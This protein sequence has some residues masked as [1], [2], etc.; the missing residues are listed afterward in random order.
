M[1]PQ[2]TLDKIRN[3]GI[4]AHID[5]GKT[6]TTERILFYT[7]KIH[8]MG[9]VH[10]GS[11][12]MDWMEQEKERGITITS[13]ATTCFW[14][15]HRINIIDTPGHIDFTVE[16]QRSLRVLDGAVLVLCAVGGVQPQ[17][18]TVW[19]QA[20]KYGV[21]RLSFINKM[22]RVGA[23]FDSVIDQMREKLGAE[24]VALQMPIGAEDDFA[25]VIDLVRLK[26]WTFSDEAANEVEIPE[27]LKSEAESKHFELVE[28]IA[29]LNESL[30]EAYL[31]NDGLNETELIAGIREAVINNEI[32]PV[33]TGSAFK[34]KGVQPLLDA[35]VDYLPA[36]Q[37]L[38]D[39]KFDVLDDDGNVTKQ[40]KTST[41]EDF[42]GLVFKIA[43]DPFVGRLAFVRCYSG[44]MDTGT[45]TY[46]P[47]QD[48][49]ERLGR[50]LL[51]HANQRE[52][53]DKIQAGE[54]AAAVGLKFAKTGDTLTANNKHYFFEKID[55]P[56]TVIDVAIEPKSSVDSK[57][58]Q[59][60][61]AKLEDE[62]PTF[63][64]KTNEDTGQQVISGM[65]ELHLEIIVDRIK[66]EFKVACNVGK[67]QVSYK[68]TIVN[69][70]TNY[71]YT[72]DREA[73][74]KPQY[75][76]VQFDVEPSDRGSGF[77][78]ESRLIKDAFDDEMKRYA[79][80][81][82]NDA[83]SAG[84][85]GGYE[86]TDIKVVL[87]SVDLSDELSTPMAVKLAS[88]I[89]LQE[90]L[91]THGAELLEPVMK[92]EIRTPEEFMGNVVSDLNARRG[93]VMKIEPSGVDQI[94]DARVPLKEMFGYSTDLR[95]ATQGRA[96]YS[97]EFEMFEI[98][99]ENIKNQILGRV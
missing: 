21:P 5:A 19:R 62:D 46:N 52:D 72:F 48:K 26:A 71:R 42:V 36:P 54:I 63:K 32:H 91:R 89:G 65:G 44:S 41:D 93:K 87:K 74:G 45:M 31:E 9:E 17:T 4:M 97:M 3:I 39:G 92:V 24:P 50:L 82:F 67:P 40:L 15:D 76:S 2:L 27:S 58:L 51:M 12:N 80:Q 34:N 57:K 96:D 43:T 8:R 23:N 49:K 88:L 64:V 29:S 98:T 66:R 53:L 6:T 1:P 59:E 90:A 30:M 13:A 73:M 14:N 99:P 55:F 84:Q 33:F 20:N 10:D 81:G 86:V 69:T 56:E 60:A 95:S 68:E 77:V 47:N 11:A 70:I 18:E 85:L 35:V 37:D 25:G 38:N 83:L 79:E 7:G 22:D 78:F 61:L 28:T 94:V 75:A 16:V